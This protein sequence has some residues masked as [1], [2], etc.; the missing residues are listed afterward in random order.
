[1]S[2]SDWLPFAGIVGLAMLGGGDAQPATSVKPGRRAELDACLAIAQREGAIDAAW[3]D[4]LRVVAYGESNFQSR[5]MAGIAT[6]SPPWAE[7]NNGPGAAAAARAQFNRNA[8]W[9]AGSPWPVDRYCFGTGGWF[10]MLP[11]A[12]LQAFLH[13]PQIL[14]DPWGVF[15]PGTSVAMAVAAFRR[16]QQYGAFEANPKFAV[17]RAGWKA[18]GR[19]S[20]ATF[21]AMRWPRW[22]AHELAA[23]V[24][25]L[26]LEQRP[27]LLPKVD[28]VQLARA[29]GGL[30]A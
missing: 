25:P 2:A 5:A 12:A 21:L 26:L 20:D 13:T 18:T 3:A 27:S 15:Q 7:R 1:M 24:T 17:L 29:M 19:M 9:F 23:G 6:G 8:K 14:S 28:Y 10:A 16:L 4:F 11:T 30:A 22:R